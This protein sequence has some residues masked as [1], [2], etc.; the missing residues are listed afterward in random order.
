M[1][2]SEFLLD[3]S[4]GKNPYK[5]HKYLWKA[6]P[7]IPE[8]SRTFLFRFSEGKAGEPFRILMQSTIPPQCS[9]MPRGCS[10][11]TAQD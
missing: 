2:L 5:M 10:L 6:F 7:N 1:H 9:T 8:S 11:L 4:V 3:W